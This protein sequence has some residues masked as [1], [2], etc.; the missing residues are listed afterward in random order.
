VTIAR[1]CI[2]GANAVVNRSTEPF[3][4]YCGVPARRVRDRNKA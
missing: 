4:L 3:G 2:V 1:G